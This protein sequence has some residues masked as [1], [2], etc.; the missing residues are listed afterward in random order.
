M[1]LKHFEWPV[2]ILDGKGFEASSLS[3]HGEAIIDREIDTTYGELSSNE[4]TR[5]LLDLDATKVANDFVAAARNSKNLCKTKKVFYDLGTGTGKVPLQAF[6]EFTSLTKCVGIEITDQR[7]ALAEQ[8]MLKIIKSGY[9]GRCFEL[10]KHEKGKII[11]IKEKFN[12]KTGEIIYRQC[13]IWHGSMFDYPYDIKDADICNIAVPFPLS[14]Y[15]KVIELVQQTKTG[16]TI[17]SYEN[18]RAWPFR[19]MNGDKC[20]DRL[21]DKP[22]F[23]RCKKNSWGLYLFEHNKIHLFDKN[24]EFSQVKNHHSLGYKTHVC[25]S[26]VIVLSVMLMSCVFFVVFL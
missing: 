24:K 14:V 12:T 15:G 5:L 6:L 18:M 21:K 7:F 4:V 22:Y 16:C 25:T 13:T 19:D 20:L 17:S 11:T 1:H 9:D 2:E 23:N 3:H 8:N 26:M 10:V